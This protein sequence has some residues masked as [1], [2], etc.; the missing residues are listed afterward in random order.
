MAKP[1]SDEAP[2]VNAWDIFSPLLRRERNPS[3][4]EISSHSSLSS[5]PQFS[6]R[7]DNP[8][9]SNT[10]N[11]PSFLPQTLGYNPTRHD[12]KKSA[13]KNLPASRFF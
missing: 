6:A 11:S 9:N 12:V 10:V 8:S 1:S 4:A 3:E 2:Q 5:H 13:Q 7:G